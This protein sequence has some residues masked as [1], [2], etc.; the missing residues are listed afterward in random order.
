MPILADTSCVSF[1]TVASPSVSGVSCP[2]DGLGFISA[3]KPPRQLWDEY[4]AWLP[5]RRVQLHAKSRVEQDSPSIYS[6]CGEYDAGR[7]TGD[8][9]SWAGCGLERLATEVWLVVPPN[10]LQSTPS[11]LHL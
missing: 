2:A 4:I 7:E 8:S 6:L 9:F 5:R 1:S 3:H 11:S 10:I